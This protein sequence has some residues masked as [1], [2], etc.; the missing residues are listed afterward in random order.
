MVM[1]PG[2]TPGG[3]RER[4]LQGGV[5]VERHPREIAQAMMEGGM[6]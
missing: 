4:T 3:Q 5:V 2:M 1:L 6:I